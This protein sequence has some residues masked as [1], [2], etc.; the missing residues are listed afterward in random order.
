MSLSFTMTIRPFHLPESRY[1]RLALLQPILLPLW[2]TLP[3]TLPALA[4]LC[5]RVYYVPS[6]F[7][8]QDPHF[9][10]H[11][12]L[13]HCRARLPPRSSMLAHPGHAMPRGC[14]SIPSTLPTS[15]TAP[16]HPPSPSSTLPSARSIQSPSMVSLSNCHQLRR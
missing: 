4:F 8:V 15:M 6:L 3:E 12:L 9:S 13:L 5:P 10:K 2:A 14:S 11:N 7:T 16:T 1:Y